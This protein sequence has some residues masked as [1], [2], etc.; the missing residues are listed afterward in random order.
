MTAG[1][2]LPMPT[3]APRPCRHPGCGQLVHDGSGF[4]AAHQGDRTAGK[5]GDRRRGSRH[6]RGYGTK[7]DRIRPR[8][9]QRDAGL[10]QECLRNGRVEAGA[11]VDH[12][13]PKFEGGA[14]DE[15]NLEYLCKACS[16]RKTAEEARR[17]RR[18]G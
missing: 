10:C 5:F 1:F 11:I 3:A 17:A 2:L 9:I 18:V 4:C 15:D 6:A 16:D 12:K 14:D 13:V 8:I 7:W